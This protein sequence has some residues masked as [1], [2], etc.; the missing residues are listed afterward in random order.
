MAF[1][2]DC[3]RIF[4]AAVRT[5]YA[6]AA[7]G[8]D[9][10]LLKQKP[11]RDL[12]KAR[13][14]GGVV[15][16]WTLHCATLEGLDL[17]RARP[18]GRMVFGS[19]GQLE[20]R[21][22]GLIDQDQW[23]QARLRPLTSRGDK[24]FLGNR[25]FRLAPDA[26]SCVFQMYGRKVEL[27]LPAITGNAGEILRQAAALA[28]AKKINITFRIDDAKLHVTV[29]PEDL[30]DHPE[31]RRPVKAI[32]GRA[33]G[34]DLN[35]SWIGI[36]VAEN[37]TDPSQLGETQ[38][39]DWKLIKLEHDPT[40]PAEAVREVLAAAADRAIALARQWGAGTIALEKGLGKLRSGGKSRK[41]NQRLNYWAR[42]VFVTMLRRKAN[43][44]GITVLEVWGGYSTTIGNL[45]FD[46]PDA[47]AAAAEIARRGIAAG[48]KIKDVLP[49]F[50]EGWRA[51]LRKDVPLPAEAGSWVDVHRGLKAAK[52][53]GYRR[54][55][56]ELAPDPGGRISGLAVRRLGRRRRPGLIARPVGTG[57]P[58][59]ASSENRESIRGSTPKS[60]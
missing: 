43:L 20:R 52:T 42:T 27:K 51:R 46:L 23:R 19:R 40:A 17:R 57:Q 50:D 7:A 60:E 41:L 9:G 37:T 13:F 11:L 45:R 12:V 35:P 10:Q 28:A 5:A 15:D 8:A 59:Q 6:N 16:A 31:R 53:F 21:R 14:A 18:D 58:R 56:P 3:R 25:H 4:S 36:A 54:P 32:A 38:A 24:L 29:D 48:A 39:L 26:R 47:C 49:A 22:K 1:L 30:P 55:H 44:A 34:V 2:K 33:V